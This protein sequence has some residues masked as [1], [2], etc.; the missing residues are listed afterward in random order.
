M[1]SPRDIGASTAPVDIGMFSCSKELAGSVC[2][3]DVEVSMHVWV[4]EKQGFCKD[5]G[6]TRVLDK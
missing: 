3:L 2:I 6:A 1:S 4:K 5:S